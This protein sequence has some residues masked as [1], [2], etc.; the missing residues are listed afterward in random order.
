MNL[1]F[2]FLFFLIQTENFCSS[3]ILYWTVRLEFLDKLSNA[4][5]LSK[6]KSNVINTERERERERDYASSQNPIYVLYLHDK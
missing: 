4:F 6:S 2:N 5:H 1:D 3:T